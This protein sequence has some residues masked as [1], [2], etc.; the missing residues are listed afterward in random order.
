[1]RRRE[2][3]IIVGGAATAWPLAARAQQAAVPV[4]GFLNSRSPDV[5]APYVAAFREGLKEAGYV[6]GENVVVEYRW[7]DNQMDRL[8]GLAADLVRRRVAVIVATGGDPP[9]V[10][11][12]Q[13]T[14]TIPI[15]ANFGIDPVE[16]KFVASLNRPGGNVTGVNVLTE[17]LI[18]K[19]LDLL[20]KLL[21]KISTV[22]YLSN[23]TSPYTLAYQKKFEAAAKALG[24]QAVI[25]TATNEREC[26]AAFAGLVRQGVEAL[27]LEGD[28]LFLSLREHF[29]ALAAQYALPV[30]Y[31]RPAYA[32][33]GGLMGYAPS[34]TDAYRQLGIYAGRILKGAKPA[35]LPVVQP[36]K[37]E[38]VINLKTAKALGLEIPVSLLAAADEVIE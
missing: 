7:A 8:P 12:T 38:L 14:T 11:A 27:V 37:F 9:L 29:V 33:A 20:R 2:F 16:Q 35:E 18:A 1:M 4:I 21:P 31:S 25:A 5:W 32:V 22:A 28:P 6:E 30:I 15:V 36:S 13:A 24:V 19:R 3:V 26:D 17:A 34:L 10:A 23:P